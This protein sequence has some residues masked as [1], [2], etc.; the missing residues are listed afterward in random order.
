MCCGSPSPNDSTNLNTT[1]VAPSISTSSLHVVYPLRNPSAA[2]WGPIMWEY[3]HNFG[4]DNKSEETLKTL[5]SLLTSLAL[6]LPCTICAATY[7]RKL[8]SH[9]LPETPTFEN[10]QRWMFDIHNLIRAQNKQALFAYENL[11]VEKVVIPDS[12]WT[13]LMGEMDLAFNRQITNMGG[14]QTTLD[15]FVKL[16]NG[17][18]LPFIG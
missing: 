1:Y 12:K 9:P 16:K 6:M 13:S 14:Y 2:I 8:V 4:V 11:Q 10:L 7:G 15:L 5:T 18:S 17:E 3:L